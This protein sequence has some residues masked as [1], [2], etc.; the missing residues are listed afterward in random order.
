MPRPYVRKL[1]AYEQEP[2][3][4]SVDGFA[5]GQTRNLSADPE[6]GAATELLDLPA[7]WA[8][9]VGRFGA[10]VEI[11]VV[12]GVLAI[13]EYRLK[14]FSYSYLPA[15][16][17]AGPWAAEAGA[18]VLWMPA[19]RLGFE[20]GADC[21]TEA[22]LERWIPQIDSSALPWQP[23]ITPGF[24]VGA[25]RKTLRIDPDSGA[26]TW[27]LGMLPQVRDTRREIHPTAEEAF[28]L[29]GES[30]SERGVSRP[31]EYFWRPPFIP[32]GPFYTDVGVLT[33]FRTDGPLRTDYTWPEP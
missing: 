22:R 26:G 14:Q 23:T 1:Y 20:A 17:A 32:H 15:G 18:R 5:G 29:L 16:V 10:G 3:A 11:L 9:P 19:A 7:G 31:G 8:A 4:W 12:E 21:S 27:L 28:T 30:H 25:M 33:F 13:G 24:P 2:V 6:T